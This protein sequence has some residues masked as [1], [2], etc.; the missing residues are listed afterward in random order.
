MTCAHTGAILAA[1]CSRSAGRPVIGAYWL[2][3]AR[4]GGQPHRAGRRA[5]EIGEPL[6]QV[7]RT[8]FGGELR[9]GVKMVVPTFGSLLVIM[10]SGYRLQ[11]M[12]EDTLLY[13][14][15]PAV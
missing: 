2:W 8:A 5:V 9:H 12:R 15:R 4:H 3:P 10:A 1:T 14:L 11:A 6:G 7:E 13:R